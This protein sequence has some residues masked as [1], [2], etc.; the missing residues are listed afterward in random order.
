MEE[1]L[2][3]SLLYTFGVGDLF[4]TLLASMEIYFFTIFLTDYAQF[5]LPVVGKILGITG[6]ADIA[7]ALIAG[8]ILQRVTLKFG[9]KFRS[10]LFI[11]PPI[12]APFF[13]LQFLKIGNNSMAAALI[14][15]GFILSHLLWNVVY[16]ATGSLVGTLTQR[17]DERTIMSSSRAQ[18]MSAAGLLFSATAV[19]MIAF[20]GARTSNTMGYSITAFVYALLMILGYWYLYKMTAVKKADGETT[21]PQI[22]ESRQSIREIVVLVFRNPPLLLLIAAEIFRNTGLF[23]V[24]SFVIFYLKYVLNNESFMSIF[25]LAINITAL[26]G[27]LA[28]AW[29]GVKIGKRNAYWITLALAGVVF[30][31]SYAFKEMTWGFTIFFCIGYMLGMVAGAMATA[32]FIDTVVYGEWK[33]GK[34]I[35]AFTMSLLTLPIKIGVLVRSGVMTIGL[36]AIGF[37][38]NTTPTQGVVNGISSIM[39][40]VPAAGCIVAA[41]IFYFGYRINDEKVVKMQAEIAAR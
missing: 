39:I 36:M 11:G 8:I 1:R 17:P 4:F 33:T 24:T 34:N 41:A 19:P 2:K 32:L 22:K 35:Q 10:W 13:L 15:V 40:F 37:V 23:M 9:G 14:I 21:T 25:I 3:K 12:I 6:I 28:A 16:A 26:A 31:L 18:G 27:T 5:S 20:F 30:V 29:L 38:A 7:C